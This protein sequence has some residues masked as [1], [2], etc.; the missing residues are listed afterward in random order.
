M[1]HKGLK[2]GLNTGNTIRN[3]PGLPN[4]RQY[5]KYGCLVIN[6]DLRGDNSVI[7]EGVVKDLMSYLPTK[8]QSSVEYSLNKRRRWELPE[9]IKS[10]IELESDSQDIKVLKVLNW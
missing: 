5:R 4:S 10:K 2:R 6:N 1:V 8:G 9:H 3:H 7:A